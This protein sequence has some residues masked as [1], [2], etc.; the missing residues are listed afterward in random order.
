VHTD[1]GTCA[2]ANLYGDPL[3]WVWSFHKWRK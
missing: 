2:V 3:V 1:Q